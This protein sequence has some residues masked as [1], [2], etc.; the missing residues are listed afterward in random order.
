MCV[1]D[2]AKA[3]APKGMIQDSIGPATRLDDYFRAVV[4]SAPDRLAL[5]TAN[6]S[7]TY[8]D[9]DHWSDAIALDVAS[10]NAPSDRPVAIITSTTPALIAAMLGVVKAG[11]FFVMIDATDPDDRIEFLLRE[12]NAAL[13]LVDSLEGATS[14]LD[15]LPRVEIRRFPV[16]ASPL[17]PPKPANP[18]LYVIYTSGTTGKPK[19]I[20]TKHH[21]FVPKILEHA[22]RFGCA[23]GVRRSYNALP[24]FTRAATATFQS[25]LTGTTMCAFD[26]RTE[27]LGMLAKSIVRD[28]TDLLNMSPSLF[29]RLVAAAPQGLDFSG[30]KKLR[31]T[32]DRVTLADIDA[33]RRLFPRSATLHL[34][35]ASSETGGVFGMAID[36][37]TPIPGP[38]VPMGRPLSGVEVWL[39]GDDGSEVATGETGEIVVRSSH[40]V[41]GYWDDPEL[42][43]ER[44]T[45][46]PGDP[47]RR[48]FRTGDL[49]KRD[50]EGLYYFV[51]RKDARLKIHGRRID[52]SEV[53]AA[54]IATGH[55]RD[56]VVVG[57]PDARGDEE[58]VAYVV[59]EGE[60]L[61]HHRLRARLRESVPAWMIPSRIYEIDAIPMTRATKVD[62]DALIARVDENRTE[63]SGAI[64][65]SER[66]L[67]EIWTRVI[68]RPVHIHD[69]FFDDLGG[70]SLMAAHIAAD[71]ESETG[72]SMAPSLLIELNT[73]AKMA[74]YLRGADEAVRHV[75]E[76]QNGT[77]LPPLFCVAGGGG[78]VL[79][80]RRLAP[81]IGPDQPFYGLQTHGFDLESLPAT[82][83]GIAASY[84]HA[85][86][87]VQPSGPYYLAGYSA[88]GKLAYEMAC[89]LQRAGER[90]AFLGLVDTSA[91][92]ARVSAWRRLRNRLE[93]LRRDPGR[94]KAFAREA[95]VR[96][97][98]WMMSRVAQKLLGRGIA[99]PPMIIHHSIMF[100]GASRSHSLRPYPGAVTLFRA[101]EGIR[102]VRVDQ[103]LGWTSLGVGRLDIID[104]DGDHTTLLSEP[105]V[106]SLSAAMREA[107]ER[108]RM[109]VER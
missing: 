107:L 3:D 26:A 23:P 78:G 24:G 19:A 33:F 98:R 103:D 11:H 51:G 96:P 37:D 31:L 41:E 1:R 108:A 5:T 2:D 100:R 36:H 61:A 27:S 28:R 101:R 7:Y 32:A 38:L 95:A 66:E 63:D 87:M 80:F 68:G 102:K 83:A 75:I 55:L 50:E 20:A 105:H 52:S 70:E 65:I 54:L 16:E 94:A 69:D 18:F 67:I 99:V 8:A 53:E 106:Y 60:R 12:S 25:L 15:E 22:A 57:K 13:C 71:V 62:R 74:E 40:V 109:D 17:L 90:V 81:A 91:T 29:R 48:T 72:K 30:V 82:F 4:A 43:A 9:I 88:G 76:V 64:D 14:I 44:F 10:C 104:V 59:T 84:V 86:R 58:L 73:V 77:T 34:G 46:D 85:I 42:T 97:S 79:I 45:I 93:I 35:Y 39:L 89:Q 56:A 92:D 47:E 21:G 6:A 49:A